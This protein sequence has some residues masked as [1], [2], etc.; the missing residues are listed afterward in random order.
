MECIGVSFSGIEM[1]ST[2]VDQL[3]VYD[4]RQHRASPSV[5]SNTNEGFYQDQYSDRDKRFQS[6]HLKRQIA[7]RERELV[8]KQH[9]EH[10]VTA[11]EDALKKNK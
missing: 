10:E 8:A 11:M 1:R 4:A 3:L 9:L 2:C 6:E 7:D 5:I